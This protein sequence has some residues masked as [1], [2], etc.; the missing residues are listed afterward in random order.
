[1]EN[2]IKTKLDEIWERYK[3]SLGHNETYQKGYVYSI[4]RRSNI[5]VTGINPSYNGKPS[6]PFY[7]DT[8]DNQ[9]FKN[10]RIIAPD[11]TYLDLFNV[12][13][14]QHC[15]AEIAKL[16]EGLFFLADQLRYTQE[17]IEDTVK[18]RLIL[19]FNKGSWGYW[20]YDPNPS[21]VWMG[22]EFEFVIELEYGRLMRITGLKDSPL[23]IAQHLKTT[24][25][26]GCLVYFSKYLN[27]TSNLTLGKIKAE[28]DSIDYEK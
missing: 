6:H 9:Y 4:P 2:K 19:V 15:I 25:L 23:R 16:Q 7:Y 24:N 8:A 12:R 3:L 1:M 17:L 26:N 10:L 21:I 11:A 27:Y 13:G 18:P 5:L 20:G 14:N 22:Y 28:V